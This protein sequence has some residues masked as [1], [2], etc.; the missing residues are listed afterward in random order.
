MALA[1]PP[2]RG[3][4]IW[5]P[6]QICKGLTSRLANLTVVLVPK[7]PITTVNAGFSHSDCPRSEQGNWLVITRKSYQSSSRN[8]L[9]MA[10]LA[11]SPWFVGVHALAQVPQQSNFT[12]PTSP[13]DGLNSF[14]KPQSP[15][16]PAPANS[17]TFLLPPPAQAQ[18]VPQANRAPAANIA[19]ARLQTYD[20]PLEYVGQVGAAIQSQFGADKRVRV[21]NEPNTGRLM[22][23]APEGTQRQIA[24]LVEAS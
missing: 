12:Q 7:A 13:R 2:L 24:Q 11:A 14:A 4:S 16:A 3:L 10:I 6:P 5:L 21:T 17:Q 1:R 9:R 18:T 8:I 20:V 22:V 19:D 23:L 15:G